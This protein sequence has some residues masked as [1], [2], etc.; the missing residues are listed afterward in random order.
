M[1]EPAPFEIEELCLVIVH[2]VSKGAT[3]TNIG[4]DISTLR[5]EC[6]NN[7]VQF[8]DGQISK[9]DT[10]KPASHCINVST[11]RMYLSR[12]EN[13]LKKVSNY[14]GKQQLFNHAKSCVY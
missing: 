10:H 11:I 8:L 5:N 13:P 12:V 1:K 2:T 7:L 9:R 3:V 4:K 6:R 14:K